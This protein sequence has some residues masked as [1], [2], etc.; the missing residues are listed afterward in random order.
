MRAPLSWLREYVRVDA[1]AHEIAHRLAVSALDVERL[2]EVGVP[3]VDGN[4]G[5]FRVGT[6]L[7]AGKHPK[8]GK[9]QPRPR[10]PGEGE[11]PHIARGARNLGAGPP[12]ALWLPRVLLPRVEGPPTQRKPP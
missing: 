8:P 5:H 1:S 7:E 4:L 10:D 11:P 2:I 12:G 6:V 9:L 3:D